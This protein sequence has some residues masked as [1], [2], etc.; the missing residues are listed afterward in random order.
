MNDA[1]TVLIPSL[2]YASQNFLAAETPSTKVSR[3][4]DKGDRETILVIA[5]SHCRQPVTLPLSGSTES[6]ILTGIIGSCEKTA[7]ILM[8]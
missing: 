3:L 7:W 4:C 2:H 6:L 5:T 8:A 1:V